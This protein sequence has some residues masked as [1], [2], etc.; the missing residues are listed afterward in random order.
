MKLF[1]RVILFLAITGQLAAASSSLVTAPVSGTVGIDQTTPGTTNGVQ[2]NAA[3]PA[4]TAL[5]GKTGIDQTTPGTTNKVSIGT[6]G[7]VAIGTALPAGAALIG[8]TG[9]DQTTPGTTNAVSVSQIGSTTVSTGNGVVGAGVQRV[10]IA[11][12]QTAFAVTTAP[13]FGT[14]SDTFT[15]TSNGTTVDA[16]LAPVKSFTIAAK[17]TG[18]VTSWTIVLECSLDNTNFSTVLTHTNVTPADGQTMSTGTNLY[19]CLYYRSRS[20]AIT[21][22]GGTNVIATIVGM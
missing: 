19:P 3:L 5:I 6:D 16:H 10:V 15:T 7:T 22:G 17:A 9:I 12:D 4:G 18:A 2:I 20:T 13:A 8:K 14:R 11:S 1:T 21:L